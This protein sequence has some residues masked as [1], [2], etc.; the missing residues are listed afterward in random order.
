MI[1]Y[2]SFVN[3]QYGLR[4]AHFIWQ[5]GAQII[6]EQ[7]RRFSI[8]MYACSHGSWLGKILSPY[9]CSVDWG[10]V[11]LSLFGCGLVGCS[12]IGHGFVRVSLSRDGLGRDHLSQG[13]GWGGSISLGGVPISPWDGT[14]SAWMCSHWTRD[15]PPCALT[16]RAGSRSRHVT[17]GIFLP[18]LSLSNKHIGNIDLTCPC[19]DRL[20]CMSRFVS[21]NAFGSQANRHQVMGLRRMTEH[22]R[23]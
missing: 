5:L 22:V 9:A 19:V 17:R 8:Q 18:N 12:L 23:A 2:P 11:R 21:V 15:F 1:H 6:L 13:L 10:L 16:L 3:M 4:T 7:Y 20:Q 14:V